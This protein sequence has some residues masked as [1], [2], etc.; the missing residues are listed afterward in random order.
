[1][2]SFISAHSQLDFMIEMNDDT[3]KVYQTGLLRGEVVWGKAYK[4]GYIHGVSLM[5]V[6]EALQLE[7]MK[8]MSIDS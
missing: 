8:Q 1:M 5:F 6:S 7:Y 2:H 4:D 3:S